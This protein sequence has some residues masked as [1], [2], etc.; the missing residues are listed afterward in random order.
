MMTDLS[1]SRGHET[2]SVKRSCFR[3]SQFLIQRNNIPVTKSLN[4]SSE[5]D[6][7]DEGDNGIE[8]FSD[9]KADSRRPLIKSL[10]V[11]SAPLDDY[12]VSR[13]VA[14]YSDSEID[15]DECFSKGDQC[16]SKR[17]KSSIGVTRMHC[18]RDIST[19]RV[20]RVSTSFSTADPTLRC[21][22]VSSSIATPPFAKYSLLSSDLISSLP[23]SSKEMDRY[24]LS[25][26]PCCRSRN[27]LPDLDF[28]AR[29][30]CF[31]YLVGAIDEA[32]A[33]Y[34]NA[35]SHDEEVA[36][37]YEQDDGDSQHA[38]ANRV[39]SILSCQSCKCGGESNSLA[40]SDEDDY[41][42][43][44]SASTSITDYDSDVCND[45]RKVPPKQQHYRVSEVPENMR[46]QKLKDRLIKAKYYL[47]DYVDSEEVDDSLL[48]WKKWDLI[49]YSAIELVEDDDEDDIVET[50]I[51]E[52]EYGRFAASICA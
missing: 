2:S 29:S 21:S 48:F 14:Q 11:I 15:D 4:I 52:L 28:T 43:E 27:S 49:K 51:E 18:H 45:T 33:R 37:G 22:S 40:S 50:T 12:Q 24:S 46:L 8:G 42:T 41:G 32:W 19:S 39:R 35:T 13:A 26:S 20:T 9:Y 10:S 16:T 36:Y 31:D 6:D 47:Q 30:R 38:N 17:R 7:K 44:F 25:P 5:N 34:C 1:H 3:K 23:K